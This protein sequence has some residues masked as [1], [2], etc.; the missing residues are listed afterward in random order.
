MRQ[1]FFDYPLNF[2]PG[3]VILLTLPKQVARCTVPLF[4]FDKPSYEFKLSNL[5]QSVFF[6]TA[7]RNK[8]LAKWAGGRLGYKDNILERYVRSIILSYLVTPNDRKIVDRIMSDFQKAGIKMTEETVLQKIRA[9]EGRI[10]ARQENLKHV[11]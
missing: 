11:D 5:L 2:I 1:I 10:R 6:R 7:R 9:I 8:I 4:S 3:I